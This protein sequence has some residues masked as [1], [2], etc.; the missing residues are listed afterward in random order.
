MAETLKMNPQELAKKEGKTIIQRVMGPMVAVYYP[1]RR[2]GDLYVI[3]DD[4]PNQIAHCCQ[5]GCDC[6]IPITDF[7]KHVNQHNR[8]FRK[9][10]DLIIDKSLIAPGITLPEFKP[11]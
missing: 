9:Y 6:D 4:G 1:Y 10:P 3:A 11:K 5:D 8:Q 7:I 2:S